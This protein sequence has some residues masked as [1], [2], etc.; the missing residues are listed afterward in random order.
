MGEQRRSGCGTRGEGAA[1]RGHAGTH[2]AVAR[3]AWAPVLL[4][5]SPSLCHPSVP[6]ESFG[7]SGRECQLCS[8]L[9]LGTLP[10]VH[11]DKVTNG[12]GVPTCARRHGGDG[13]V[14]AR[15]PRAAAVST[16]SSLGTCAGKS[17]GWRRKARA[18]SQ[19]LALPAVP[20]AGCRGA[21]CPG[22][23]EPGALPPPRHCRARGHRCAWEPARLAWTLGTMRDQEG[24]T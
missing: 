6:A 19:A 1:W 16:R 24:E 9:T 3:A 5:L 7:D 4:G 8:Q 23:M 21:L 11:Q 14:P 17:P 15:H 10:C 22:E 2:A 13:E 20:A 18:W 12:G